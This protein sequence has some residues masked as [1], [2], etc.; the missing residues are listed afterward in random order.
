MTL[1]DVDRLFRHWAKY[2]PVRAF[3]AALAGF[4]PA[5]AAPE[6]D[7]PKYMTAEDMQ[8]LMARTGGKIPGM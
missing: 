2:P 6:P 4:D 7:K 3:V 1:R 8:R 5:K